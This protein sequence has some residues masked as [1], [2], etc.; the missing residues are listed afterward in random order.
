MSSFGAAEAVGASSALPE[1][2]SGQ[3]SDYCR[4]YQR[5]QGRTIIAADP[6]EDAAPVE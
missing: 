6:V 3:A 2:K 1:I 5:V 4:R